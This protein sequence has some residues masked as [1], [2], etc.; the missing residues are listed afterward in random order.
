MIILIESIFTK[1][2][3]KITAKNCF[4]SVNMRDRDRDGV[5]EMENKIEQKWERDVWV[6][7]EREKTW[8]ERIKE[9]WNEVIRVF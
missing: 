3:I 6:V 4:S 8:D 2:K 7:R 1:I 5:W 9:R